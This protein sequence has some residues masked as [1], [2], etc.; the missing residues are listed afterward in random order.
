[1]ELAGWWGWAVAAPWAA[2]V[3]PGVPPTSS[4]LSTAGTGNWWVPAGTGLSRALLQGFVPPC[5]AAV[6]CEASSCGWSL[7]AAPHLP[8]GSAQAGDL[9]RVTV[10]LSPPTLHWD[11]AVDATPG[12]LGYRY[13]ITAL[14]PK[15]CNLHGPKEQVGDVAAVPSPE[16]AALMNV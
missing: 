1:M 8:A 15:P 9:E 14:S 11:M 12:T 13:L 5:S 2:C 6:P 3:V 7:D 10:L 4:S 16:S